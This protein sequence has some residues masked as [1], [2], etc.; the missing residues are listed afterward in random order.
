MK[1]KL[2]LMVTVGVVAIGIVVAVCAACA[3]A[4]STA[5]LES[6]MTELEQR[7]SVLEKTVNGTVPNARSGIGMGLDSRIRAL[8]QKNIPSPA[9]GPSLE[10]RVSALEN[11]TNSIDRFIVP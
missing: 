2:L 4:P 11:K 10:S 1:K 8:E 6:R 9:L 5:S 7:V 3:A